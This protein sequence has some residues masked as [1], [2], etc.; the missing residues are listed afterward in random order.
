MRLATVLAVYLKSSGAYYPDNTTE[1]QVL[2]QWPRQVHVQRC[3]ILVD[4][5]IVA[6]SG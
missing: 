3:C 4:V 5:S 1:A 6:P 2:Q